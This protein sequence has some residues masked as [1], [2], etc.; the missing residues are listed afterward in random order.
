MRK[1]LLAIAALSIALLTGCSDNQ[2]IEDKVISVLGEM[3]EIEKDFETFQGELTEIEQ[4]EQQIFLETMTLTQNQTTKIKEN[5]EKL[6]ET[7]EERVLKID[8]EAETMQKANALVADLS[9]LEEEA[10]ELEKEAVEKVKEATN[11]RYQ[12]HHVFVENYAQ[13]TNLQRILYEMIVEV[14]IDAAKLDEQVEAVNKQNQL[15]TQAVKDFNEATI[16]LNETRDEVF[17]QLKKE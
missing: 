11:H 16:V 5:V 12:L 2:T 9:K 15:V 14:P 8:A 13:F 17:T 4:T 7:L 10:T 1:K 3:A 6:T